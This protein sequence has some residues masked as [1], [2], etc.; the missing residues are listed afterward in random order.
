MARSTVLA[1]AAA[2][3]M[4][5]CSSDEPAPT[6]T[7][8]TTTSTTSTTT[9]TTS[10]LAPTTTVA[11]TTLPP[12]LPPTTPA[13][14]TTLAPLVKEGATVLVA[15]A[16]GVSGAAAELTTALRNLG[17]TLVDPVNAAGTEEELA[18]SKVYYRAGGEDVAT[19]IAR[20]MGDVVT[21]PM[22]TP[23]PVVGALE[24][25]GEATV[26]VMLGEDLAGKTLPGL[27]KF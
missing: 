7:S 21:L 13:P 17:F 1:V 12:T 2:V 20:L 18:L 24:G 11:P 15:N 9:S 19:S 26:L 23:P 22:P 25:L 4:F 8:S 6:T 5:A 16:A 27:G 3:T 14:T 10:T